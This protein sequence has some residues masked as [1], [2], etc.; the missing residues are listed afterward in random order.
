VRGISPGKKNAAMWERLLA[1]PPNGSSATIHSV[2]SDRGDIAD[3][4]A[5]LKQS[6][7]QP[8][9]ADFSEVFTPRARLQISMERWWRGCY[10]GKDTIRM[11]ACDIASQGMRFAHWS[12]NSITH[13]KEGKPVSAT[14][15][16]NLEG[17]SVSRPLFCA[18]RCS[19]GQGDNLRLSEVTLCTT[20]K[21]A[22][23]LRKAF[24]H[25]PVRLVKGGPIPVGF[26]QLKDESDGAGSGEEDRA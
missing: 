3:I 19:V 25:L 21:G 20:K 17:T 7:E 10:I 13:S 11:V 9:G 23:K 15:Y 4:L 5:R 24:R 1:S 16:G 12:G 2:P 26:V 18:F 6:L 14:F 8:E 22:R